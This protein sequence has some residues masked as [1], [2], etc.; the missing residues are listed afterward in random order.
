MKL[1]A[2][3]KGK[4]LFEASDGAHTTCMDAKP[5]FGQDSA[6][7]P[8]QHCLAAILGCT[9]IDVV[10]LMRKYRQEMMG[11]RIE[12]D[13]PVVKAHPA[14]FEFVQLDFFFEGSIDEERA[15]EAVRLSQSMYCGVS[16]MIAK[17]CP[18]RYRIHVNG[19][20]VHEGQAEFP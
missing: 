5:P 3:W 16:A 14:V 13:A 10:G 19:R 2:D 8:K 17:A 9:G 7:S 12:A 18:I 20:P 15:I 1:T 4:A 11:L 6:L